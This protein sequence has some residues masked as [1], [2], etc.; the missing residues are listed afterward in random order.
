VSKNW[1]N[2]LGVGSFPI[3]VVELV[4]VNVK[5]EEELEEFEGSFDKDEM[6]DMF[7]FFHFL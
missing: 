4:E 2:N 6:V 3:S 5:F 1:P 7:F